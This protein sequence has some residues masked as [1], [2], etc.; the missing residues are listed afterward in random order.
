MAFSS[1]VQVVC[2]TFVH[3]SML[4]YVALP[5]R[6][7]LLPRHAVTPKLWLGFDHVLF[8][9]STKIAS[10]WHLWTL[11]NGEIRAS[12]RASSR[13]SLH[14]GLSQHYPDPRGIVVRKTRHRFG[15]SRGRI[16]QR[17]RGRQ[18]A[19]ASRLC[20][21]GHWRR[22]LQTKAKQCFRRRLPCLGRHLVR[23]RLRSR[24]IPGAPAPPLCCRPH[25]SH[26]QTLRSCPLACLTCLLR[27]LAL[28]RRQPPQLP[29]LPEVHTA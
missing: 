12:R 6:L 14:W 1:V 25:R 5:D 22:Q 7:P 20:R 29:W 11:G 2:M 23:V 24:R 10:R 15:P 19:A 4:L 17:S 8:V 9:E 18:R 21:L 27:H 16:N 3:L 26:L 28:L 13:H